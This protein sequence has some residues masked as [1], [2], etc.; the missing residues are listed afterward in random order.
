MQETLVWFLIGKI[1]WRRDRL[2]TPVFLG[3]PVG[4]DGKESSS[5]AGNLGWEDTL[6]TGMASH[7]SVLAWRIPWTEEPGRLQFIGS[8]SQ[9]RLS[10]FHFSFKQSQMKCFPCGWVIAK[11]LVYLIYCST[12]TFLMGSPW[13]PSQARAIREPWTSSYSSWFWKR[14]RN[15]RSS[16]QHPLDHWK[17]KR[18]P[19]KHLFLLYWLCQRLQ[20]CGSQ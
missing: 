19:E 11:I 13:S 15:Q 7:S 5:N 1:Y 6:E 2:P 9:T 16:C 17:S 20:L 10:N 4:L 14:Q 3:F 18:V 8:Q 12:Y